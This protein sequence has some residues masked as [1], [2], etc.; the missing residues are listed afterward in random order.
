MLNMD[1]SQG[2]ILWGA[3]LI[4]GFPLLV[5]ALGETLHHLDN[6][7]SPYSKLAHFLQKFVVPQ[8]VLL[9]ILNKILELPVDNVL[10]KINAT[11]LWIFVIYAIV[12]LFN[13][14]LFPQNPKEKSWQANT[15]KLIVNVVRAI[16]VAIGSAFVLSNVWGVELG[17]MFAALGVGSLVLGLALQDTM[18]SLFSGFSL[19]SSKQ[20]KEG[21]WLKVGDHVGKVIHVSWRSTT[22]LNREEDIIIIPNSDLAKGVV[23]NF[24]HP[25]PR[26]VEAVDF[27]FSFDDA[28]HK[29]KQVL[30]DVAL[31]TKGILHDPMPAVALISYDEFSVRHT[32]RFWL[33]GYEDL[34]AIR[35]HFVSSVWYAASREGIS[36][37]TRAHEVIT[38][39]DTSQ[40]EEETEYNK[41]FEVLNKSLLLRG[42][43]DK[44]LADI[45]HHSHLQVFGKGEAIIKQNLDSKGFYMILKGRACEVYQDAFGKEHEMT[46]LSEGEFCGMISL[47]RNSPDEFSVITQTDVEV[48]SIDEKSTSLLLKHHPEVAV[49]IEE[50][51]ESQQLALNKIN[52]KLLKT[53]HNDGTA[54]PKYK[55]TVA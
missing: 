48:V 6:T 1:F 37:P 23:V 5:V 50:I 7:G 47:V 18:S 55:D 41:I 13:I 36:F 46:C 34:P 33:A 42:K 16:L 31:D 39:A 32:I 52:K 43:D 35:D 20:F 54:T 17:K 10:V 38:L 53:S 19:I 3:I 26:T 2:W 44:I 12:T 51:I 21:D 9:L 24:S 22:L 14:I 45:A 15:P 28:P 4:I 25:Y 40:A 29:V 11:L 27:D 8:L 30:I 49:I